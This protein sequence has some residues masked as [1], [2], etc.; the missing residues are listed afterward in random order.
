MACNAFKTTAPIQSET[1]WGFKPEARSRDVRPDNVCVT[2][3][4]RAFLLCNHGGTART[5]TTPEKE[6]E[7]PAHT[8]I[9]VPR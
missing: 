6:L 2:G 5:I 8:I 1:V 3:T 4:P 7:V 9:S